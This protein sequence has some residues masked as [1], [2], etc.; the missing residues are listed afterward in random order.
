MKYEL[1]RLNRGKCS[2][3]LRKQMDDEQGALYLCLDEM[4]HLEEP[5]EKP[6]F[7]ARVFQNVTGHDG[8]ITP[9]KRFRKQYQKRVCG[10]IK[11]YSPEYIEDMS[12]DR[13]LPRM[14]FCP[15]HRH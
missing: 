14:E 4:L 9:S 10:I 1:D 13:C 5:S 6:I 12:E 7:S 8:R 2:E 11:D 3:Q 15:I